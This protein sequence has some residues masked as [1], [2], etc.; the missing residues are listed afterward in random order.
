MTN[1]QLATLMIVAVVMVLVTVVLHV[2]IGSP[3]G[4]FVSGSLLIQGLDPAK[5]HKII[6]K[7][8][9][10]AV[11]LA[12]KEGA[13]FV[14]KER[15]D[16][17]ASAKAINEL[18]Y[19]STEII[20]KDKTTDSKANHEELGVGEGGDE[21]VSV[22]F[23]GAGGKPLIGYIKGKSAKVGGAYVRLAGNDTV[24]V[25]DK[26]LP[27][28][29]T[30]TDYINKE[31]V[32][33]PEKDIQS[34]EVLVG[35]D[36]YTISAGEENKDRQTAS[37]PDLKN[38]AEGKRAKI[39]EVAAVFGALASLDMSDVAAASKIKLTWNAT[40]TCHLTSG[41][42]YTIQLAKDGEKHYAKISAKGPKGR[43]IT[44]GKDDSPEE[45]RKKEALIFAIE[46]PERFNPEHAPWVYELSS[47]KAENLRRPL[48]ELTEDIP[49]DTAPEEI[50]ASH[51]LISYKGAERS[52]ATRTKAA[53][54]TL[55]K[56]V[57]DLAK[58]ADADFA[59]LAEKHSDGPS[60][61][62]GGDLG[63]FKKGAMAKAFEEAAF[64]L[65]VGEISGIVE[66]P[67]GFHIIKRTK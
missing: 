37:A 59:S 34:V 40:Y 6:I 18:I 21:A 58:A 3:E 44:V 51:I 24:Y 7:G 1:K 26:Y 23:I 4:G 42:S 13:G 46:T 11:T 28:A 49:K 10:D 50:S 36:A 55:A 15:D 9:N 2:G 16:Y 19:E 30:P 63:A 64:K 47:W 45:L 31:I 14:V 61:S 20:C 65:K 39:T 22:S 17:P 41:L 67:F 43:E 48:A 12:R 25:S 27:V 56:T 35:K 32:R 60:K 66:T 8:K 29:E 33:I 38:I 54:K 5:V 52:Q 62:K 57:L 53:A